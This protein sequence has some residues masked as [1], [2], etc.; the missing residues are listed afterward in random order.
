[1][2]KRIEK[3]WCRHFHHGTFWPV[4][5]RYRCSVCLRTWDVPWEQAPVAS[6]RQDYSRPVRV[7]RPA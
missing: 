2:I 5:G 1:M 4:R 7:I 3:W 6:T